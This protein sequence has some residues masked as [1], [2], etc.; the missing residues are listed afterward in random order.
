MIPG[1]S[2]TGQYTTIVPLLFVLSV[3]AAKEAYEDYK[4][5]TD[6]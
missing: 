6:A 4:V 2:P 5:H 3:T 1:L